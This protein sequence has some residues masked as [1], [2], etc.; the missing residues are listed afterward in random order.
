MEICDFS[1][2]T[3]T[4]RIDTTVQKPITVSHQPPYSLNNA[5]IN[6]E[7]CCELTDKKTGST[8]L[9]L[10]GADC[11]TER[12]G[13]PS[14]IW[15]QPNANFC[16]VAS[17]DEFL[18]IKSWAHRG[19][20]VMLYPESLGPQPQRQSDL[21]KNAWAGFRIDLCPVPG[22]VLESPQAIV[23]ASLQNRPLLART[24]YDDGDYHVYILH[25]IKT[26]SANER[27]NIYQTDTGPVIL[28]DISP[29]RL[30]TAKRKIEVFDLA[31]SAFNCPEWAE[32]IVNVPTA[33]TDGISVNH[34]SKV[35]RSE[36][37]RNAIIQ[38][39]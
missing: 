22:K 28:P 30:S 16:L 10:L 17:Q 24:E 6:L 36:N 39:D 26:M 4:F 35:R 18:I 5:R 31:Y 37:T 34:Y 32:F 14:Y 20:K 1:R 12:V 3:F 21:V 15:T 11:K 13:V 23:Q 2:S 38:I 29:G 9:Y 19:V 25:P 33:V 8:T 7:C 27:D